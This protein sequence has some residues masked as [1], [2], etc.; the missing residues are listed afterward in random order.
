MRYNIHNNNFTYLGPGQWYVNVI[1]ICNIVNFSV[2][3]S[4]FLLLIFV[5]FCLFIIFYDNLVVGF[6]IALLT[7]DNVQRKTLLGFIISQAVNPEIL[8]YI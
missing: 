4:G 5:D 6:V 7:D 2:Y 1:D 8:K 3:T